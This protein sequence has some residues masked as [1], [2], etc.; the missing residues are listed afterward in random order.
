MSSLNPTT[1]TVLGDW[2]EVFSAQEVPEDLWTADVY[3]DWK[4]T[5]F[6]KTNQDKGV[7]RGYLVH[8]MGGGVCRG[9]RSLYQS[10]RVEKLKDTVLE[11]EA[12]AEGRTA[13]CRKIEVY[14]LRE[15]REIIDNHILWGNAI[16]IYKALRDGLDPAMDASYKD[17]CLGII[18]HHFCQIDKYLDILPPDSCSMTKQNLINLNVQHSKETSES[19]SEDSGSD[20]E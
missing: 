16:E 3:L 4:N 7:E 19:E 15:T 9:S 18:L 14:S 10:W 20:S 12:A 8:K 11:Y 17:L 13:R 6:Y 2:E 1:K 5:V